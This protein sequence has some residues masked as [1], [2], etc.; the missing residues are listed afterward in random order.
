MSKRAA[1]LLIVAGAVVMSTT[2]IYIRL[3]ADAGGFQILLYRSLA[4]S[5]MVAVL[6]CLRRRSGLGALIGSLDRQDLYIGFLLSVAFT[7]FVFSILNTSVAS[8]LFILTVAP[9]LAASIAWAWL[10][11]KPHPFTWIAMAAA[12]SGIVL[13]IGDGIGEG[14]TFGNL[15]ALASAAAFAL[16]L[17]V[18]RKGRKTDILGGTFVGGLL[19]GAYGLVFSLGLGGGL[20]VS[21]HDLLLVLAMGAFATGLGIG[22]VTWATPYIPAAEVSVLVLIESALGPILVWALG[23]EGITRLEFL[24]GVI[25]FV[26]VIA[27][28]A[29]TARTGVIHG[30]DGGR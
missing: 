11:E 1:V 16:M 30:G 25:V 19:S 3:I 4:L 14:R 7:G 22:L 2:G 20:L 29:V 5:A 26:A 10:G 18:A 9:L 15:C 6:V 17:A 28:S 27:L 21:A 12:C 13:M 24:G 8:T 23:F